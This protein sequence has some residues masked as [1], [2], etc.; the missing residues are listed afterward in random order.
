MICGNQTSLAT[1]SI[2]IRYYTKEEFNVNSKAEW[3]A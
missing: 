3:S 1:M 2:V